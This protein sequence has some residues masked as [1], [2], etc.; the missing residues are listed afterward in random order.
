MQLIIFDPSQKQTMQA[1]SVQN[2]TS[3]FSRFKI[4]SID[5][6]KE[7]LAESSDLSDQEIGNLADFV[8]KDLS[9][10]VQ[11]AITQYE[12]VHLR[13]R[14]GPTPLTLK[15]FAT[16]QVLLFSKKWS[17]HLGQGEF[18][19]T[20][21]AMALSP[22]DAGLVAHATQTFK[23]ERDKHFSDNERRILSKIASFLVKHPHVKGL[24]KFYCSMD[25]L[26]KE[27]SEGRSKTS[28]DNESLSPVENSDDES[29][30]AGELVSS[31]CVPAG[32]L[33]YETSI[34]DEP[35]FLAQEIN[36]KRSIVTKYY[37]AGNLK[38]YLK[39]LNLANRLIVARHI[40]LGLF[41]LHHLKIFHSDLKLDNIFI[42]M[43]KTNKIVLEAVIGDYGFACDL[44]DPSDRS[45]KDGHS[46]HRP[47]ELR[48][49]MRGKP[50]DERIFA[51][52]IFAMG[53]ILKE[54]CNGFD[55]PELHDLMNQMTDDQLENR[56]NARKVYA[57]FFSLRLM[58][59]GVRKICNNILKENFMFN[60]W[61]KW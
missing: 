6:I 52:D 28:S 10:H 54:L 44:S 26:P 24:L 35:V 32:N 20:W 1:A 38:E 3:K 33:G 16:G 37:N 5:K 15:I 25:Y 7:S 23:N 48:M 31:N 34:S 61:I 21:V 45:Y 2:A 55:H 50:I 14:D 60:A 29:N 17:I 42:R 11:K 30:M 47:P 59:G 58:D 4:P 49:K 22:C 53:L 57:V 43:D 41:Y 46:A 13:L 27:S 8:I 40:V 39:Y 12:D 36:L 56:P 9:E 18:R 51:A 19:E